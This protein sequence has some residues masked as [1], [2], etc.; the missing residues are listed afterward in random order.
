MRKNP[1]NFTRVLRSKGFK[2]RCPDRTYLLDYIYRCT[3]LLHDETHTLKTRVYWVLHHLE[4]FPECK[5]VK[6][7]KAH[8]LETANVLHI[9]TGYPQYCNSKC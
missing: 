8:K 9:D 1:R 5:N 6:D 2:N 4:D 3:P 7:G